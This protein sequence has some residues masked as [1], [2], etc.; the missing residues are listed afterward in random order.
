MAGARRLAVFLAV[1]LAL[2]VSLQV[3]AAPPAKI[4][5]QGATVIP[6]TGPPVPGATILVDSGTITAIGTDVEIPYDYIVYDVAG[7]FV[8][9]GTIESDTCR[10]MDICNERLPVTPLPGRL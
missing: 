8:F 6:I 9:P 7:K 3:G 4:A 1:V 10:G 2:G 5:L